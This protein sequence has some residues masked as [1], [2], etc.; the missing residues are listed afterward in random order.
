MRNQ[1][2]VLLLGESILMEGVAASLAK[3]QLICMRHQVSVDLDLGGYIRHTQPDMIIFELGSASIEAMLS[4]LCQYTN[5]LILGLDL[6]C[7]RAVVL[8]S[9]QLPVQSMNDLGR[10]LERETRLHIHV[11]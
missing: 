10:L 7:Q 3:S 6:D 9:K 4:G 1:P 11:P 5:I 2:L 8:I